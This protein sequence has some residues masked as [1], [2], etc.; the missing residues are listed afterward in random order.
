MSLELLGREQAP[1][2]WPSL[3]ITA[4]MRSG[5]ERGSCDIRYINVIN[6][7]N[8]P[9]RGHSNCFLEWQHRYQYV[10]ASRVPSACSEWDVIRRVKKI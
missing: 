4:A 1:R 6:V 10:T 9:L 5:H 7:E 3:E 8:D 2:A